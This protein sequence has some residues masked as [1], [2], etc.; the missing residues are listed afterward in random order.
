MIRVVEKQLYPGSIKTAEDAHVAY[1][2]AK[3]KHHE[4]YIP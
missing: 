4:G 1:V 3:L 2:R